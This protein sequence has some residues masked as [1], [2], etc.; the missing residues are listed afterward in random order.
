MIRI[1]SSLSIL[2][3]CSGL[4][5]ED[6]KPDPIDAKKLSGKWERKEKREGLSLIEFTKDGKVTVTTVNGDKETKIDGTYKTDGNKLTMTL[7]VDGKERVRERTVSKL[8]DA[9]FTSTNEKGESD[10]LVRVKKKD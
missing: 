7:T 8:T 4:S 6:K 5:A 2:V 1:L 3:L 10:T 9:E